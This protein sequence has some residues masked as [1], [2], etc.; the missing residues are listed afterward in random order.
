MKRTDL[1]QQVVALTAEVAALRASQEQEKAGAAKPA[2]IKNVQSIQSIQNNITVYAAPVTTTTNVLAVGPTT[3]ASGS[4]PAGWPSGWALP[5]TPPVAFPSSF[6]IPIEMLKQAMP[7]SARETEACQRG[8]PEAVGALLTAIVRL[9]HNNPCERNM[10]LNPKRADQVLVYI[11]ERW[12]VRPLLEAVGMLFDCV[13]EEIGDTLLRVT[14]QA[15]RE[16]AKGAHAGFRKKRG[17]VVRQSRGAIAAHLTNMSMLAK[18]GEDESWLGKVLGGAAKKVRV[19]G[20]EWSGHLTGGAV[21]DN[22]E[23]S[24]QVYDASGLEGA[25]LAELASRALLVYARLL[26]AGH[27]ENLAVAAHAQGGDACVHTQYG[28]QTEPASKAAQKQAGAM[29]KT[30][31]EWLEVA[32]AP[33]FRALA[34]YIKEH[35]EDLAAEEGAKQEILGRYARDAAAYYGAAWVGA[36][37]EEAAR[38]AAARK[39]QLASAPSLR[40]G[41]VAPEDE[42]DTLLESLLG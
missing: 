3:I 16:T 13:A 22:L 30:I 42:L 4:A 26:L 40:L 37:K 19:L 11:P 35:Q 25:N 2:R 18:S 27:P 28:W 31:V 8:E 10:Y 17:E 23:R 15:D 29:L 5:R 7:S 9:I 34:G 14:S 12:E 24:L 1:D 21:A 41:E 6:T 39:R 20:R 33:H 36:C 32:D 38:H